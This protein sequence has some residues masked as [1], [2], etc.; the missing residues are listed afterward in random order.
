MRS[1]PG[2]VSEYLDVCRGSQLVIDLRV[3]MFEVA[4]AQSSFLGFGF[5]QALRAH[6]HFDCSLAQGSTQAAFRGRP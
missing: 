4:T 1:R 6:G 2:I 5:G 3:K